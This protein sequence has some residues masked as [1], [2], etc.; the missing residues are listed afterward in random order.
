MLG[1][2]NASFENGALLLPY[3][4]RTWIVEFGL[5]VKHFELKIRR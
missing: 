5:P 2:K 3:I 1:L 4:S